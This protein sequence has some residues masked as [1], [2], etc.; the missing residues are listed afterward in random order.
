MGLSFDFRNLTITDGR[1]KDDKIFNGGELSVCYTLV[2]DDVTKG[3]KPPSTPYVDRSAEFKPVGDKLIA[4]G[5]RAVLEVSELNDGLLFRLQSKS[6]RVS[7]FGINLPFNFMGKLGGGGWQKQ[8]LFNSPYAS[9]DNG[10][11]YAY[12]TKPDGNNLVVAVKSPSDG[13]KM[14]YSPYLCGHYFVNLKLFS[15]FD[16]AYGTPRRA[17]FLEFAVFPVGDFSD[18]LNKLAGF[19]GVPFADY[20]V[21]GGRIGDKIT[22]KTFGKCDG[23]DELW[24]FAFGMAPVDEKGGYVIENE[25]ETMLTPMCGDVAGAP[26]S[27]YGYKDIAE[28]YLKSM[29]AVSDD[30]LAATDGNLC[31]HQ[32]WAPATL[33]FLSKYKDK[34]SAQTVKA[35][36]KHVLELL[37]VVT[38]TDAS[39]AVLRRT[40]LAS[41]HEGFPA[42]NIFLSTRIQEEFFGITLL[43]DAYKYF[44]DEKYYEYAVNTTDSFLDNYQKSDGRIERVNE[45]VK[46]DYTTVCCPMIPV[47]DMANFTAARDTKRS[48]KYFDAAARM[49]EYLYNRGLVFPTEGGVSDKAESEMEDGS[50]S[51]T[52]LA[53]LYYC[54]NVKRVDRYVEKAKDILD[55]HDA[56]VIKTPISQMHGSSLRWW[57]TQW[58]GDADGPAICAGHAWT[59]WRAEAD[60]LY[61]YLTKDERYRI[62][63]KNGFMTNL[64]KIRSDGKTYAIYNPD[65]INGGGFTNRSDDIKFE[66]APGFPRQT[67]SGLSRYVWIRLF[68]TFLSE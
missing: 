39:K 47:V 68:D 48:E 62:K 28:L 26:V 20:D 41:P 38:E 2:T 55:L 15:N 4:N 37:D 65:F 64:S 9:P 45:G 11:V 53:L 33:R 27:V 7:E 56:W 3:E 14:D 31:E 17:H 43:L 49:A 8:F 36:E 24:Q 22:I 5:A 59:V 23:F 29:T 16:R 32:C 10:I 44:G 58:E 63:A 42:Y 57:E 50:I 51:C 6:K 12:L 61:W 19:Y 25:G 18:C 54:K 52:A 13:W 46:E 30:D 67:D 40:I 1:C 35:L 34:V 66:I 21:G 60:Y